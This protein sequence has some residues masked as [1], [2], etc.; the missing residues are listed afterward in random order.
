MG[1]SI[2]NFNR[3]PNPW[4]LGT[5]SVGDLPP[6]SGINVETEGALGQGVGFTTPDLGRENAQRRT[7]GADPS[8]QMPGA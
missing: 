6:Q 5:Q 1:E 2:A 3:A 7:S 8:P 4:E